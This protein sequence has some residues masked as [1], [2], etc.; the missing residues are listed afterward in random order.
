[1]FDFFKRKKYSELLPL[2]R[3][4]LDRTTPNYPVPCEPARRHDR[5]NRAIPTLVCPWEDG[6]PGEEQHAFGLTRDI[7]RQGI[8]LVVPQPIDGSDVVLGFRV[9]RD[10]PNQPWYF[11]GKVRRSSPIGGGYWTVGVELYQFA[12][13]EYH[14]E[15][16]VLRPLTAALLPP[17]STPL[18]DEDEAAR[19]AAVAASLADLTASR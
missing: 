14:D 7:S 17:E 16:D 2:L 13:V 5:Y 4:I 11:L 19:E 6:A 3:R 8:G 9:D 15:L 12:N 1:M 10:D 18:D